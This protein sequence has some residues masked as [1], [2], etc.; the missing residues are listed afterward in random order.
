MDEPH[1]QGVCQEEDPSSSAVPEPEP[2]P[3]KKRDTGG[4]GDDR[5][6]S[7]KENTLTPDE[8]ELVEQ[9]DIDDNGDMGD[10]KEG[11]SLFLEL[12]EQQDTSEAGDSNVSEEEGPLFPALFELTEQLNTDDAGDK[13]GFETSNE[14]FRNIPHV[15]N[16]QDAAALDESPGV[17]DS[18]D[19]SNHEQTPTAEEGTKAEGDI[20][21]GDDAQVKELPQTSGQEEHIPPAAQAPATVALDSLP[22]LPSPTSNEVLDGAVSEWSDLDELKQA[23]ITR[24]SSDEGDSRE[25]Q[26][27]TGSRSPDPLEPLNAPEA[28]DAAPQ[29]PE[30]APVAESEEVAEDIKGKEPDGQAPQSSDPGPRIQQWSNQAFRG[31]ETEQSQ[32]EAASGHGKQPSED[33][34]TPRIKLTR[35]TPSNNNPSEWTPSDGS[36]KAT[37]RGEETSEKAQEKQVC[38]D[39][40]EPRESPDNTPRAPTRNR[41]NPGLTVLTARVPRRAQPLEPTGGLGFQRRGRSNSDSEAVPRSAGVGSS[42]QAALGDIQNLRVQAAVAARIRELAIRCEQRGRGLT[43]AEKNYVRYILEKGKDHRPFFIPP[44][45]PDKRSVHPKRG[46]NC[47]A[48]IKDQRERIEPQ[49]GRALSGEEESQLSAVMEELQPSVRAQLDEQ[50]EQ[51]NALTEEV[52]ALHDRTSTLL[53]AVARIFGIDEE[54]AP[55]GSSSNNPRDLSP[56]PTPQQQQEQ[57]AQPQPQQRQQQQPDPH[58]ILVPDGTIPPSHHTNSNS[59]LNN[60]LTLLA[61]AALVWTVATAALHSARLSDGLGPYVNGGYNGLGGVAVFGSW[62]S[63]LAMNAAVV[64]LG[65]RAL[66]GGVD[67]E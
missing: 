32:Q 34:P 2:E 19:G 67:G 4:H 26:V 61:L 46:K 20:Q 57:A 51:L 55:A 37:P 5:D 35:P 49:L 64:W 44:G 54:D 62:T 59:A 1:E 43:E 24:R 40:G 48:A 41:R 33:P 36:G 45:S 25:S 22:P 60:L 21:V 53:V 3:T 18:G 13:V 56:P 7:G 38:K 42:S 9:R 39:A 28:G 47:E 29:E 63:L 11:R 31:G 14:T 10:S 23:A 30:G 65:M 12:A 6:A 27:A 66:H 52:R 8:N 15:D 16:P 58:T 17:E 50:A